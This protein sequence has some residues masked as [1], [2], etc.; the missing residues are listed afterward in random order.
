MTARRAERLALL[1]AI[2]ALVSACGGAESVGREGTVLRI[3]LGPVI[4]GPA[5]GELTAGPFDAW[6]LRPR[7]VA[8]PIYAKNAS[9]TRVSACSAT[10][11]TAHLALTAAHCID[12][13]EEVWL[14]LESGMLG[15]P[16]LALPYVARHR[17]CAWGR[18]PFGGCER[19]SGTNQRLRYDL[20][21]LWIPAFSDTVPEELTVAQVALTRFPEMVLVG[22]AGDQQPAQIR[23]VCNAV[24]LGDE[25]LGDPVSAP[26]EVGDSGGALIAMHADGSLVVLGVVVQLDPQTRRWY[27]ARIPDDDTTLR[28]PSG[29]SEVLHRR[30]VD[31]HDEFREVIQCP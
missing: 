25:D 21:M 1:H 2:I 3:E 29:A 18:D 10:F 5:L 14:G 24:A 16:P 27:F 26:I 11:V 31:D 19:E 12:E 6:S 30:R 23:P 8:R 15:S 13:S 20:G 17:W 7:T 4:S 9:G 22:F 28:P